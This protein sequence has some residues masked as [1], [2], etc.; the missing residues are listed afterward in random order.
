MLTISVV[1]GYEYPLA[2]IL[3]IFLLQVLWITLFLR[4][5]LWASRFRN[6]ISIFGE[7]QLLFSAA[8][9]H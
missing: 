6:F 4:N 1:Y 9:I 2:C 8:L 3:L 5:K 7:F